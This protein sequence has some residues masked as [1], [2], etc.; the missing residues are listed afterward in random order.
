MHRSNQFITNRFR[1]N[2]GGRN[3]RHV[4]D[5][6]KD[7]HVTERVDGKDGEVGLA[8]TQVMKRM[9]KFLPIG[10]K[11]VNVRFLV[12]KLSRR[13][14]RELGGSLVSGGGRGKGKRD[15]RKE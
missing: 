2:H 3:S 5:V 6:G 8:F 13:H 14:L 4:F 12:Q 1:F 15:I 7:V 10:D 11:K 9:G